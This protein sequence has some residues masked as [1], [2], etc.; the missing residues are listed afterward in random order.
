MRLSKRGGKLLVAS[1]KMDGRTDA[2]RT[3]AKS[4][5][6]FIPLD[7]VSARYEV[8]FKTRKKQ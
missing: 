1:D 2:R 5:L 3:D 8:H 7:L 6:R 4:C